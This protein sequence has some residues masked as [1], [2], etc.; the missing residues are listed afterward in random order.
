MINDQDWVRLGRYFAGECS[1]SEKS[2]LEARIAQDPEFAGIV[3]DL[4]RIRNIDLGFP[5]AD[6]HEEE[7]DTDRA[8]KKVA[9]RAGIAP[10]KWQE[11]HA[12]KGLYPSWRHWYHS[13]ML[14]IAA[15]VVV[16]VGLGV[17]VHSLGRPSGHTG[18]F[19]ATHE[20]R[21]GNGQRMR[22]RLPDGTEVTLNGGSLFGYSD[23]FDKGDRQVSIEGEGFF[24][25][26]RHGGTPFIVHARGAKLQVV[27]TEFS[28]KAWP[29]E[30]EVRL[31]VRDGKVAFSSDNSG[32]EDGAVVVSPG[33]M[34]TL[35][36]GR[37]A[38]S[39]RASLDVELAWLRG[40]LVF[41]GTPFNIV[42]R[43]LERKFDIHC[44]VS[45]STILDR[46]LTATFKDETTDEVLNIIAL[47]LQL[48]YLRLEN[49]VTFSVRDR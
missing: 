26:A 2:D 1:E 35:V 46:R 18:S 3:R 36:D 44:S 30:K 27:G 43:S 6:V 8:W 39:L 23:Q 13:P 14:R 19:I 33:Q 21:V 11:E 25:V 4:A 5:L 7:W 34:S 41:E 38:A 12:G 22:L 15:S 40:V 31:V 28:V 17:A 45:D 9:A 10:S 20:V 48:K 37:A 29:E 42:M 24:D 47:S 32:M 49:S 16:I